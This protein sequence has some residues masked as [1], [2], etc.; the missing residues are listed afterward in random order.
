MIFGEPSVLVNG[1]GMAQWIVQSKGRS[2][3]WFEVSEP[4]AKR[5]QWIFND[6]KSLTI[7][8]HG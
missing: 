1:T 6:P 5:Q 3:I 8:I 7:G 2:E 4:G